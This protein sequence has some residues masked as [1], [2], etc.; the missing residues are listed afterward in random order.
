MN[1]C[2]EHQDLRG[3]G[4]WS[5][6][7]YIHRRMG[8]VLLCMHCSSCELN[9]PELGLRATT[10]ILVSTRAFY[11]SRLGSYNENQDSTGGPRA[12]KTLCDRALMAMS[13]K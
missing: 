9:L 5:V 10:L 8:I 4:H 2:G 12:R 7:P 3:S 1:D 13:S 6:T 11:S